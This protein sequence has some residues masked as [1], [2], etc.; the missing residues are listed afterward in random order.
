MFL[1]R[2]QSLGRIMD[3]DARIAN[4]DNPAVPLQGGVNGKSGGSGP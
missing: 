3:E 1:L 4:L 2:F